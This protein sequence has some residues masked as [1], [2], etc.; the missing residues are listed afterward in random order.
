MIENLKIP[1]RSMKKIGRASVISSSVPPR[2]SSI[3][4]AR[5]PGNMSNL[6]RP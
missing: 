5:L 3:P 6:F 4:P 2:W 1:N